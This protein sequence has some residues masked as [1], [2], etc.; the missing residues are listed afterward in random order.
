MNGCENNDFDDEIIDED[1][2][3]EQEDLYD[4]DNTKDASDGFLSSMF[5]LV[6]GIAVVGIASMMWNG[7]FKSVRSSVVTTY[8]STYYDFEEDSL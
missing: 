5:S 7:K 4:L 1:D 6:L 3:Q 2:A 8:D